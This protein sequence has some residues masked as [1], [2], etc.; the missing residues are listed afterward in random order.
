MGDQIIRIR[1]SNN[2]NKEKEGQFKM[3]QQK[4]RIKDNK[5]Q[6]EDDY[7]D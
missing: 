3:N 4:V 5:K 1:D 2:P 7:Y 6:A